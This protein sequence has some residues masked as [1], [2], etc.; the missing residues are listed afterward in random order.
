MGKLHLKRTPE[1]EAE[2]QRHKKR[3]KEHKKST[4]RNYPES[5][6]TQ[7]NVSS[8]SRKWASDDEDDDT[9]VYGPPPP[10]PT[11]AP[12][13]KGNAG[14]EYHSSKPDYDAIRAELEE[15]R[16][17]ERLFG[18]YDDEERLDSLEAH[19]NDYAHVP[20]RWQ[21]EPARKHRRLGPDDE[22]EF[23]QTDPQH[24]DDEEYA[25]WIRLGMYRK[26]HRDE[27]EE[28]Q[29][30]KARK[31]ERKAKEKAA[32]EEAKRLEKAMEEDRKRRRE[33]KE[34]MR[35]AAAKEV[36]ES[37]WAELLRRDTMTPELTASSGKDGDEEGWIGTNLRFEDIPWPV[38]AAYPKIKK[39]HREAEAS[40][41]AAALSLDGFTSDAISRF[42]LTSASTTGP[43]PAYDNEQD[44]KERREKLRDAMLRFHPDKFEGRVMSRVREGDKERVREAVGQ[45]ARVLNDLMG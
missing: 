23:L 8:T 3:R 2:R 1:E 26:T 7:P 21:S 29:R 12:T 18:A 16:F 20:D 28:Q 4:S 30:E 40:G 10:P 41:S 5:S 45:V 39:R 19:L 15:Q 42:V 44:K 33:E 37:R 24:L 14:A 38:L 34:N 43:S 27:Y 22:D 36:Y 9:D 31:K 13:P 17:R 11:N 35:W 32:K 25:E 6:P